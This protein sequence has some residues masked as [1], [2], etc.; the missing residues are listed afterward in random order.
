ME[1]K[2]TFKDKEITLI[3]YGTAI[4]NCCIKNNIP[5]DNLFNR[6]MSTKNG[7]PAS[8]F[9]FDAHI[10]LLDKIYPYFFPIF[11]ALLFKEIED[12]GFSATYATSFLMNKSS[13]F[14]NVKT[15]SF[16]SFIKYSFK[17]SCVSGLINTLA[18]NNIIK[19]GSR[20]FL[21]LTK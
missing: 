15:P 2:F 13:R 17:E 9:N 6:W 11:K 1:Y 5:F 19:K 3:E 8:L 20:E 16:D 14:N 7:T 12:N 10:H 18:N 21:S 4:K